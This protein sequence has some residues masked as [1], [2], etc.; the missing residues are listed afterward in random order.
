MTDTI[1]PA[2]RTYGGWRRPTRPGLG[3]LGLL[4]TLVF[5]TGVVVAIIA[6][7][8]GGVFYAIPVA[9]A[10]GLVLAPMVIHDRAGRSGLQVITA[11]TAWGRGRLVGA[12]IY[13]S[14][15]LARQ[16]HGHCGL[17]GLGAHLEALE[18]LDAWGRPFAL[19]RHS[20]VGHVSVVLA[21]NPEG[22]SLVDPEQVDTWVGHWSA[23]LD[24]LSHEP[25]VVAAQVTIETAPDSGSKLRAEIENNVA[26]S[27]PQLARDVLDQIASTYPTGAATITSRV[28]VTWSDA[29]R[30]GHR[31]RSIGDIAVDI[32]QRLPAL[33]VGLAATGAGPARPMNVAEVAA[34][35][36]VAYDP[37]IAA[38][39]DEVGPD[40]AG[41][42]W[43]DCG[44]V[45]T[46]ETWDTYRHDSGC[47]TSW[48]M[49]EP[50][51]G[52]VMSSAMGRLLA[53]DESVAR[54]RV[55]FLLRPHAPA[56]A[57]RLVERDR[58]DALFAMQGRKGPGRARDLVEVRATELA[59]TEEALG[60]ALVRFG[61]IVTATVLAP[62]D[63]EAAIVAVENLATSSRIR[64]R[65]ACGSQATT[66]LAGLPLGMV[67]PSH[68]KVPAFIRDAL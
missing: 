10:T 25:G 46:Q 5:L 12:N 19:L 13:K 20:S 64:L 21:T 45:G 34:A 51:R 59:A 62:E 40:H 28:T 1:A 67:L 32:G 43:V 35:I 50:P 17:P 48:E 44:P 52:F 60:A 39:V 41:V 38:L 9:A 11:R 42:D 68:L 57:T 61:M 14:G 30:P 47:S 24:G 29:P 7:A 16:G 2:E 6:L 3:S 49:A 31:R 27:A 37:K 26:G 58:R 33:T 54:K 4:G 23:W 53:P 63:L 22:G 56:E 66:F 8:V 15:A 55:S 36:R 18:A 65:R